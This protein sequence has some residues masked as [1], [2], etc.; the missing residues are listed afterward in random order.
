[1]TESMLERIH[2]KPEDS[3]THDEKFVQTYIAVSRALF[4]LEDAFIAYRLLS[5][6]YSEWKHPSPTFIQQINTDLP[7]IWEQLPGILEHP[8]AK[9]F[10]ALAERFDTVFVLL[11]DVLD[12]QK[13]APGEIRAFLMQKEK[14]LKEVEGF[15]DRRFASLRKR[16]I[17][18]GIFSTLSVFASNWVTFFLIEVPLA[19]MFAEGFNLW[20]SIMDF[21]IPTAVMFFLVII[22]RPPTPENKK[23]VLDAVEAFVYAGQSIRYYDVH[24]VRPRRPIMNFFIGIFY[25]VMIT[26]VLGAVAWVFWVVR[27]PITSVIFDTFT[28]ALTVFAAVT[29]RNKSKELTVGEPTSIVEFFLDML[30]VPVA[31]FGS[32]LAAKWKEYNIIAF[33]FTYL[34]ETPFT[35][36]V[37]VIES[38]S[39]FLK[40]RRA[41]LH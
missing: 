19:N 28:I 18:L 8:L 30:S 31:K 5:F 20:T 1:M 34:I 37:D 26:G 23:R 3:L 13:T 24:A 32:F 12:N 17:N 2:V 11:G 29:I 6:Q 40:E 38:W 7:S 41:E 10:Y 33:F 25:L 39:Q 14:F 4:D 16:L 21:V 22:I 9:Q 15:Y 36:I 27:L 35:K